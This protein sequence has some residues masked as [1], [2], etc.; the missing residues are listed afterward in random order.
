MRLRNGSP[1]ESPAAFI[2]LNGVTAILI[3]AFAWQM[4]AYRG[5][6]NVLLVLLALV[7]LYGFVTT[8]TTIGRRIYAL[9]GTTDVSLGKVFTAMVGVHVLIGIGEAVITAATVGAVIAVR[10]DLVHGAR[11]LRRPLELKEATV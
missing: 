2:G 10:P 9:G 5:L 7:T 8:R 4:S 3:L 1:A 6:P 11:D